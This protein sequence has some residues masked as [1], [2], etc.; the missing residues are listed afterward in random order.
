MFCWYAMLRI[1]E[2]GDDVVLLV[3]AISTALTPCRSSSITLPVL[4]DIA[5][6]HPHGTKSIR[7]GIW[8]SWP[9][10]RLLYAPYL[11]RIVRNSSLCR[12]NS[13][14][15]APP[16]REPT[17]LPPS[18]WK[19]HQGEKW[20]NMDQL[21]WSSL[22]LTDSLLVGWSN[23]PQGLFSILWPN[24]KPVVPPAVPWHNCASL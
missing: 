2:C 8:L 24:R 19:S 6:D 20:C 14:W 12:D 3:S 1:D 5:H 17:T 11:S 10:I 22:C 4:T 7:F 18:P 13:I 15:F 16:D 21:V 23:L 9:V